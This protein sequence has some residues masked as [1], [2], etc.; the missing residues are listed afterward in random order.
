MNKYIFSLFFLFCL[1]S[2]HAQYLVLVDELNG[3][4]GSIEQIEVNQNG[5]RFYNIERAS[6]SIIVNGQFFQLLPKDSVFSSGRE[7][8]I[9]VDENQ[10]LSSVELFWTDYTFLTD[11]SRLVFTSFNSFYGDTLQMQDTFFVNLADQWGSNLLLQEI[12]FNS[13]TRIKFKQWFSTF[14]CQYSITDAFTSGN[15]IYFSGEYWGNEG[16][17]FLDEYLLDIGT[18]NGNAFIGMMD[19]DYEVNWLKSVSGLGYERGH[20]FTMNSNKHILLTGFSSSSYLHFCEDSLENLA[21]FDW[22]TD[23]IYFVQFDT[24]GNCINS[25]TVDYYYGSNIPSSICSLSDGSYIVSGDYRAPYLGFD[26]L[27]LYIQSY[28]QNVYNTGFLAKLS[29][30]LDAQAVFQLEGSAGS[31]SI[32]SMIVDNSDNILICG[33]AN[34]DTLII[35][36]EILVNTTGNTS[37]GYLAVLDSDLNV[38]SAIKLEDGFGKKL[39]LGND[40]SIYM[41]VQFAVN[42]HKLFRV[43]NLTNSLDIEA[44][45]FDNIEIVV[46]PNPL[47]KD[48]QIYYELKNKNRTIS[49][50]NAYDVYGQ[51]LFSESIHGN[52][53]T[54]DF[55]GVT[56]FFI[57]EFYTD[58]NRRIIRKII[59]K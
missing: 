9:T 52:K 56:G 23:F 55:K 33:Y 27:Y 4:Y 31:K 40:G 58:D 34:V 48:G 50:I 5:T 30:G 54:C 49:W 36:N 53:G 15:K 38:V 29:D 26:S 14:D 43:D 1:F 6:D 21:F 46:F 32:Q 35:G 47:H 19:T 2:V 10:L 8:S 20:F 16:G 28:N 7:Y 18:G 25:K 51:F 13:D 12:D 3:R 45:N 39:V 24:L 44:A 11:S 17:L 42:Q 41:L 22:G 57:L 59:I 37:F